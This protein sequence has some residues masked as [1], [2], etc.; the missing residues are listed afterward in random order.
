MRSQDN[1]SENVSNKIITIP[2]ILTMVRI[3]LV[4]I[5]MV[6]YIGKKEYLTA[7]ILIVAANVT[8]AVDG[9]VARHFHMVSRLGKALDPVADKLM[10]AGTM[11]CL[12]SRFPH[13]L[14][15]LIVIIV[16]ETVTGITG[17][18]VIKKTGVVKSA[19]WHGK[20]TTV[21]LFVN[22]VLHLFWEGITPTVSDILIIISLILMLLS[23][24]LYMMRY[25]KMLK[26][27][28]PESVK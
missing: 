14:W 11:I 5:F 9:F 25:I 22:M 7:A 21:F 28:D 19:V 26:S 6:L 4:P 20:L 1:G 27:D 2:N 17:L 23:F 10:Q 13:M 12:V 24:T 15:L 16:K 18:Y 8:D 3:I